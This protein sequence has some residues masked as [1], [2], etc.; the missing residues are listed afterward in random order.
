MSFKL[1]KIN[2][3]LSKKNTI[4]ISRH[5]SIYNRY[6]R[7]KRTKDERMPFGW[8]T[9]IIYR[10]IT[11]NFTQMNFAPRFL[12]NLHRSSVQYSKPVVARQLVRSH[13]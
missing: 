5:C 9:E 1:L 8:G 10:C 6:F 11:D 7:R 3:R 12:P 2:S 4:I 13:K